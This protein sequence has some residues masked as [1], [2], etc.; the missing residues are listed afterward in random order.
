LHIKKKKPLSIL[1]GNNEANAPVSNTNGFIPSAMYVFSM[2]LKA[3]LEQRQHIS[4]MDN[5]NVGNV[6]FKN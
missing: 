4:S 2:Q 6:P 1:T 3:D 5:Q